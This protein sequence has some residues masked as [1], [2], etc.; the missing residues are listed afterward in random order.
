[1]AVVGA[2]GPYSRKVF[3]KQDF[4]TLDEIDWK[5]VVVEGKKYFENINSKYLV[6]FNKLI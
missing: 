1:M 4:E 6:I 5:E 2:T 3:L